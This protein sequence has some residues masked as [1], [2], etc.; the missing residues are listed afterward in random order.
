MRLAVSL[1]TVRTELE[2]LDEQL[3][4][5]FEGGSWHGPSVREALDGVTAE[6]AWRHPI[7]GAHSIWELV[8]HLSG[9]YSLVLRRLNGDATDLSPEEDWP[10]VES[11]STAN[12]T[13]ALNVLRSLNQ[14]LRAAV[15]HFNAES[16]DQP[17][18]NR[19]YTAYEQFI[20][21]TQHD[22]YHA[23]QIVLLRRA[24]RAAAPAQAPRPAGEIVSGQ[25]RPS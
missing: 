10:D 23:G 21:V 24:L 11:P 8:L 12:W 6:D 20:G 2:R 1:C 13:G 5:S 25:P 16:L 4:C 15:Q 19:K 3:R 14:Q 17:L 22:L 18:G 9:T 7:P